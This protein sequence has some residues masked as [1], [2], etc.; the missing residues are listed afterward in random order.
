MASVSVKSNFLSEFF[1]AQLTL[2]RSGS[3]TDPNPTD[4][5]LGKS[6]FADQL[7]L[8]R[9]GSATIALLNVDDPQASEQSLLFAGDRM[10][11][12]SSQTPF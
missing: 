10:I 4:P 2:V 7:T 11:M 1:A 8:V 9:S 3:A 6:N 5:S 12:K